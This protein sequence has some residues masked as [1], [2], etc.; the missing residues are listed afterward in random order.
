MHNINISMIDQELMKL[1][2]LLRYD[3]N[4]L[5][6][7]KNGL[8]IANRSI[9]GQTVYNLSLLEKGVYYPLNQYNNKKE[10]YKAIITMYVYFQS[11]DKILLRGK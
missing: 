4:P 7:E 2:I 8:I 3:T 6:N 9:K 5:Y 11:M 10:I 1:N